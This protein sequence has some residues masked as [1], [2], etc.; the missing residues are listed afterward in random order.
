MS[1]PSPA[2]ASRGS[3]SATSFTAA[4]LV[5]R[6]QAGTRHV[7]SEALALS[8]IHSNSPNYRDYDLTEH[9]GL[10]GLGLRLRRSWHLTTLFR[11]NFLPNSSETETETHTHVSAYTYFCAFAIY[12]IWLHGY[13]VSDIL[14]DVG[15]IY[16]LYD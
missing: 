15:T 10:R 9:L 3:G 5:S 6:V 2:S 1:R 12:D 8:L 4:G 14:S 7:A 11:T 13:T 16:T